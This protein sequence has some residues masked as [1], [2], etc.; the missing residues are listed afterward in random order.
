MFIDDNLI[1][2]FKK[3]LRSE[4]LSEGTID[5]YV[6]SVR[7]FCLGIGIGGIN[8]E[9]F[10]GLKASGLD[11]STLSRHI[12]AIK[13]FGEWQGLD[14]KFVK[15][16]KKR[17]SNPDYLEFESVEAIRRLP[18]FT[19]QNLRDRALF[20][21]LLNTGCRI[22]EVL[23]LKRKDLAKEMDVIGK[24]NKLRTIFLGNAFGWVSRYN[25]ERKDFSDLLFVSQHGKVWGRGN[26]YNAIKRL[27][28][29]ADYN[30]SLHPHLLRH[31]YITY[32]VRAGVDVRTIQELC[33][34]E[35]IETTL[36]YV[37]VDKKQK[38]WASQVF[39][40]LISQRCKVL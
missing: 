8:K 20:E 3:Y 10:E 4:F 14:L 25:S 13:K 22:S 12:F 6:R 16:K 34:H 17:F 26:A 23:R 11:L 19:L 5:C 27:G 36:R 24:G 21:F 1:T 2:Q 37:A 33:G 29:L 31:T 35:D 18:I 7:A 28:K 38:V 39:K 30:K 15:C 9:F 40:N 32:M